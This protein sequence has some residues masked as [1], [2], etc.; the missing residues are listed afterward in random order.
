MEKSK[1]GKI[2]AVTSTKG[3]V[4]KTI[5][6]T[7]LAGVYSSLNLKTLIIDLDIYGGAIAT[8][9]NSNCERNIYNFIEDYT[10]NR[11]K[12]FED[13]IYHYNSY[14]DALSSVKDPRMASK[15]DFKY[16]PILL[17]TVVYKY[18]VILID[19]THILN[20]INIVTLDNAD[21]ILYIFTNDTF[22]LKN[23]RSFVNLM[24]D[25]GALN[26]YTL[27]NGCI[28]G[29]E[30]YSNYDIRNIT[31]ANID[32]TL[33]KTFYIKNIDKYIFDSVI[34]T[35]DKNSSLNK[36]LLPL[37]NALLEEKKVK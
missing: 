23:T 28:S 11:Y 36:K 1:K 13:Y 30:Y 14:I 25:V 22:D 27:L 29:K 17:D 8:Y 15:I 19:T 3:G 2:I 37:A 18:D 6:T 32:F 26:Y 7:L 10:H 5:I 21:N 24:N 34:P 33:P 9:L 35:L 20:D 12:T 31:G 4:G 16:I